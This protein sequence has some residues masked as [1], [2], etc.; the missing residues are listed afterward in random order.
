MTI[1]NFEE[2]YKHLT[3]ASEYD[4]Y[5]VHV[6]RRAKDFKG[7]DSYDEPSTMLLKTYYFSFPP[8][9]F[10]NRFDEIR[11][12]CNSNHARAYILPQ[13][14][15]NEECLKQLLKLAVDNLSSASV[16]PENLVRT[17]YCGMHVSRDK[18]WII[19]LDNDNMVEHK[20]FGRVKW[21][22]P[23]HVLAFVQKQLESIGRHKDDAYLIPTVNGHCIVTSPFNLQKAVEECNL[24]F[25]GERMADTKDYFGTETVTKSFKAHGWLVKDGMALL[26]YN[27]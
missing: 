22:S 11:E 20:D 18:K 25:Q 16:N 10:R 26:Y 23:E 14:R 27:G 21:W 5:I 12:Y 3:F 8:E 4:K 13:V 1:D 17:A 15:N 7:E 24:M 2:V 6:I 9:G 19:D